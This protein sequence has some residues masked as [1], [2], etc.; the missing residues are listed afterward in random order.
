MTLRRMCKGF[1]LIE[2]LVVIAIIGMLAAILSVAVSAARKTSLQT[3]C[4]N[5]LKQIGVGLQLYLQEESDGY[6]PLVTGTN[7]AGLEKDWADVLRRP[8]QLGDWEDDIRVK[9]QGNWC[10]SV[11]QKYKVF[12][13][14]AN[15]HPESEAPGQRFDFTYNVQLASCPTGGP[16]MSEKC[17]S[18][19]VLHDHVNI[20]N[21]TVHDC[22]GIH[23][24]QDN[25]LFLSGSVK[26]SEISDPN[27]YG[28]KQDDEVP[29]DPS[30]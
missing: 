23:A 4:V 2:L 28:N 5:N 11:P 27:G 25:F 30:K 6:L 8:L 24:G 16:W 29:W 26:Q 19:V 14:P 20:A 1:T 13:C 9:D 18:V 12:A 21:P 7:S 17:G 3:M 10:T 22:L 15:K